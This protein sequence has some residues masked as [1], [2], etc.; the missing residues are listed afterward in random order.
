MMEYY[1]NRNKKKGHFTDFTHKIQFTGQEEPFSPYENC[2]RIASVALEE[3]SV[4]EKK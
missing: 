4:F 3:L 2:C 1:I